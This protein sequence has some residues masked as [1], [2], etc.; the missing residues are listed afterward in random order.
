VARKSTTTRLL[1]CNLDRNTAIKSRHGVDIIYVDLAKVFDSVVSKLLAKLRW[2]DVCGMILRWRNFGFLIYTY[3]F[4]LVVVHEHYV[5]LLV[6]SR[7][8]VCLDLYCRTASVAPTFTVGGCSLP[9]T[10]QCSYAEYLSYRLHVS[11]K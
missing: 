1:E 3:V 10:T 5:G 8:V 4:V 2:Y 9:V 6:E 7:R 11:Y